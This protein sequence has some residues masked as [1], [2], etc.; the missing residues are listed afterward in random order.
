MQISYQVE[1]LPLQ[2]FVDGAPSVA[3]F[4]TPEIRDPNLNVEEIDIA[5]DIHRSTIPS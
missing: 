1:D 2:Q 3:W 4:H 5:I